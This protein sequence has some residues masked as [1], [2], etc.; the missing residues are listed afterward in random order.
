[1]TPLAPGDRPDKVLIPSISLFALNV[2]MLFFLSLVSFGQLTSGITFDSAAIFYSTLLFIGVT[3]VNLLLL[4]LGISNSTSSTG[5]GW[6]EGS[7]RK[8]F[9]IPLFATVLNMGV[10]GL[11]LFLNFING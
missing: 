4:A 8:L 3:M 6:R 9:L 2:L 5:R 1:M 10:Y 11:T 7:A